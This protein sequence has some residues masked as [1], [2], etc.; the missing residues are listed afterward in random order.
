MQSW[1][2]WKKHYNHPEQAR[3]FYMDIIE[4]RMDTI[5][6]GGGLDKE[7]E[8]Y[9]NY[10]AFNMDLMDNEWEDYKIYLEESLWE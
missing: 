6:Y 8:E 5:E 3:D 1:K 7:W 10:L 4:F 2:V 9:P